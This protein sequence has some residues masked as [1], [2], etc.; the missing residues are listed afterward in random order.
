MKALLLLLCLFSSAFSQS[1]IIPGSVDDIR[2][3]LWDDLSEFAQSVA[4]QLDYTAS[5][6][7][8]PTT[9]RVEEF[10]FDNLDR[11]QRDA[12][13]LVRDLGFNR[14]QWDCYINHYA[15]FEWDNLERDPRRAL[16]TLGWTERIWQQGPIPDTETTLW[17]EL[18][19]EERAAALQLCFVQQ[20]WDNV[21]LTVW[22]GADEDDS[23]LPLSGMPSDVPSMVPSSGESESPTRLPKGFTRF[24]TPAPYTAFPTAADTILN[25]SELASV[26]PSTT[27]SP[28]TSAAPSLA[29]SFTMAP[30]TSAAPSFGPNISALEP[31]IVPINTTMAPSASL[32]MTEEP[33]NE[34]TTTTTPAS[35]APSI[36]VTLG[37]TVSPSRRPVSTIPPTS[38]PTP[39]LLTPMV[40]PALTLKWTLA[41][42]GTGRQLQ[43]TAVDPKVLERG[44]A[45]YLAAVLRGQADFGFSSIQTIVVE[46][47]AKRAVVNSTAFFTN[48]N[49]RG[50]DSFLLVHFTEPTNRDRMISVIATEGV[51]LTDL[52]VEVAGFGTP[53][54]GV[55]Q[56][57]PP[58]EDDDSWWMWLLIAA[59]GVVG[60]AVLVVFGLVIRARM[61]E[62]SGPNSPRRK[63]RLQ[64]ER[65]P[66]A[67]R[68]LTIDGG[69]DTSFDEEPRETGGNGKRKDRKRS[70]GGF[71]GRT[72]MLGAAPVYN[73]EDEVSVEGDASFDQSLMCESIDQSIFTTNS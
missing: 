56:A 30:S 19:S 22:L 41:L 53:S 14:D 25:V 27:M 44:C 34:T 71:G 2:Y 36:L 32:N 62:P 7:N 50:L 6:W 39:V 40:L 70:G 60:I 54:R 55:E 43:T 3:I 59:C 18:T 67:S 5:T 65:V 52:L 46:Q 17:P 11:F 63:R 29:P 20:T 10:A 9:A 69:M 31:S 1:I 68:F 12:R 16:Q 23:L 49:V 42:P 24:P 26:A 35:M 61:Q 4:T 64:E 38:F 51:T 66:S 15:G 21:T 73:K 47:G 28:S 72:G 58:A 37:P 48:P 13:D 8:A 57:P 33:L 45:K